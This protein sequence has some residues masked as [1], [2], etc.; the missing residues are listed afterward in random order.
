MTFTADLDR[1]TAVADGMERIGDDVAQTGL[2]LARRAGGGAEVFGDPG[3]AA[4]CTELIGRWSADLAL[5]ARAAA[6]WSGDVRAAARG[7]AAADVGAASRF[8]PA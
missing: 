2:V 6:E 3:A 7:Y 5:T 1:L 4:A 8:G